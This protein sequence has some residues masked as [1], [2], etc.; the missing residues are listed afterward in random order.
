MPFRNSG[1][2]SEREFPWNGGR[3]NGEDEFLSYESVID[4]VEMNIFWHF[5]NLNTWGEFRVAKNNTKNNEM[6]LKYKR[7]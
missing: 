2:E 3:G 4:G 6:N 5:A 1:R 7:I